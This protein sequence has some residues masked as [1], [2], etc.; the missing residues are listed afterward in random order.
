MKSTE[1]VLGWDLLRGLC[2]F[3]VAGYHLLYWQEITAIHTFGSYG[4]YLFFV[5]SGASLSYTYADAIASRRFSFPRFLWARYLRLAPLY[6]GLMVLV[7]PW[8]LMQ[9]GLSTELFISYLTNATFLFGFYN[10]ANHALLVGGWSLGIEAIFYL[11][12][13]L[14]MMSFRLTATAWGLFVG[15]LSLQAAWILITVAQPDGYQQ[16]YLLYHQAPA[17]AAY[18]M[19]GCLIGVIRHQGQFQKLIPAV[20]GL[21]GL[22]CGFL[23]LWKINPVNAGGELTGWRG[24]SSTTLCFLMV[25][26]ASRIELKSSFVGLAQKFGDST[27]GLYLMHPVIFF[28]CLFV[29]F[30]R[31]GIVE[32]VQWPL[33]GR[34][35]FGGFVIALALALALASEKYFEK[36][37]RLWAGQ[38]FSSL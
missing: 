15:L 23:V 10:P 19:G 14:L 27:Y 4:V 11:L 38:K 8:K 20:F 35:A 16:N 13:P 18:F 37:L 30:P 12:F 22:L 26:F 1:R 28:G 33:S 29:L 9:L 34:L 31:L 36:P 25:F 6:V 21:G 17:F 24:L 32:P 7:F 3:C 2:A 5:L